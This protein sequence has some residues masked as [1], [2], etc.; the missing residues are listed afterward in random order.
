LKVSLLFLVYSYCT[1]YIFLVP[2]LSFELI[3]NDTTCV[4]V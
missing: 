4:V 1:M 2:F 3:M